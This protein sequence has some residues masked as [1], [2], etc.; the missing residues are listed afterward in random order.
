M[1][2]NM[3]VENEDFISNPF[4]VGFNCILETGGFHLSDII[5]LLI[6]GGADLKKQ[7]CPYYS[8]F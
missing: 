5:Y 4:L 8:E 7:P 6:S 1:D 3:A 2:K